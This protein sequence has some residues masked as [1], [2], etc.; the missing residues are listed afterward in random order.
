MIASLSI[1]LFLKSLNSTNKFETVKDGP[2]N[3]QTPRPAKA[4]KEGHDRFAFFA[5]VS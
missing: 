1:E 3:G 2:S 5:R 4:K